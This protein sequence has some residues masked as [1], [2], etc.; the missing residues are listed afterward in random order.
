MIWRRVRKTQG[1]LQSVTESCCFPVWW[2][3]FKLY[4]HSDWGPHPLTP[5]L[6]KLILYLPLRLSSLWSIL[7]TSIRLVHLKAPLLECY[8]SLKIL[9]WLCLFTGQ[10]PNF[11]DQHSGLSSMQCPHLTNPTI[12]LPTSSNETSVLQRKISFS[13]SWPHRLIPFS[14]PLFHAVSPIPLHQCS[15]SSL[16]KPGLI[17]QCPAQDKC[18]PWS[19]AQ[20]PPPIL[21]A[22]LGILN[23]RLIPRPTE[24]ESVF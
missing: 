16:S 6:V 4:C 15:L 8:S 14:V 3:G 17:V 12:S 20:L 7:W 9:C 1:E 22:V 21:W 11:L 23:I 2:L 13:M 19:L 5:V 24:L 10:S 18:L